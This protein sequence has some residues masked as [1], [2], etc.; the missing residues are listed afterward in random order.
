LLIGDF[1]G[2]LDCGHLDRL[3]SLV[4]GLDTLLEVRRPGSALELRESIQ[5]LQDIFPGPAGAGDVV[6]AR[7]A[8]VRERGV[9]Y[10]DRG[11]RGL[12]RGRGPVDSG[13]RVVDVDFPL[14]PSPSQSIAAIS[15][16][17]PQRRDADRNEY[18][19]NELDNRDDDEAEEDGNHRH[20]TGD[21][22]H[23]R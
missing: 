14:P 12:L 6:R 18:R 21:C 13:Y 23:V 22:L 2:R 8:S 4:A 20:E 3:Q 10:S 17:C 1:G 19:H 16:G 5:H 9:R 15:D 11:E 7:A